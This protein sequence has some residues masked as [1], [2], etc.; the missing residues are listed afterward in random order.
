MSDIASPFVAGRREGG[1]GGGDHLTADVQMHLGSRSFIVALHQCHRDRVAQGGRER[2]GGDG[3]DC[4]HRAWIQ[5]GIPSPGRASALCFQPHQHRL[6]WFRVVDQPLF[7]D[8]VV[9]VHVDYPR[10][11]DVSGAC[12]SHTNSLP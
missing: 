8:K 1:H 3:A 11:S 12:F 10:E 6:W 5:N 7:A 9:F 2:S 4:F